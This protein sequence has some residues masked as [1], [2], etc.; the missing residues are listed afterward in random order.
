[1]RSSNGTHNGHEANDD[2]C[3]SANGKHG[4]ASHSRIWIRGR[5]LSSAYGKCSRIRGDRISPP[6][7][8]S[9]RPRALYGPFGDLFKPLMALL[10][11]ESDI[12][13]FLLSC[14]LM[15]LLFFSFYLGPMG[16]H[17]PQVRKQKINKIKDK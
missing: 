9:A 15:F 8:P 12:F 3:G 14:N 16:L 6:G 10:G 13:L 11:S 1:M 7:R 4:G 17:G 5:I 2:K